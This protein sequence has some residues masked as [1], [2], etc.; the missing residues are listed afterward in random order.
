MKKKEVDNMNNVKRV[1]AENQEEMLKEIM[2]KI[3]ERT[4]KNYSYILHVIEDSFFKYDA[5]QQIVCLNFEK[6]GITV[7]ANRKMA[8]FL[9]NYMSSRITY[10][11]LKKKECE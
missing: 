10:D 8:G 2:L 3:I 5:G 9:L 1:S 6:A 7:N 4:N 11:M